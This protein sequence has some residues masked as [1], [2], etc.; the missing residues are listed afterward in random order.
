MNKYFDKLVERPVLLTVVAVLLN[1]VIFLS[2]VALV[3]WL[4]KLII[5]R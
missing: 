2:G 3:L 1:V 4:V 5:L